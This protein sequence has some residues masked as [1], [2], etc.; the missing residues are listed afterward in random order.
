MKLR[1]TV[2][3]L[4]AVLAVV[5]TQ[6]QATAE[7]TTDAAGWRMHL[8]P[9]PKGYED[10]TGFVTGTG[11]RGTYSG[12]LLD[13][14]GSQ[15]VTWTNGKPTLRGTPSEV[16]FAAT[17][18]QSRD[19]TV[20]GTGHD[21]ETLSASPF[22]LDDTGFWGLSLPDGA[23][24]GWATAINDRGDIVGNSSGSTNEILLWSAA[25]VFAPPRVLKVDLPSATA[26]DIDDDGTILLYSE[27]GQY[28]WKDGELTR[29]KDPADHSATQA[30]AISGGRVVGVASST[31]GPGSTGFLWCGSEVST[32]QSDAPQ[33]LPDSAEATEINSSELI[34]GREHT[35]EVNGPLAVWQGLLHLGRLPVP[36]GELGSAGAVADDGTI[37]GWVSAGDPSDGGR[38]VVWVR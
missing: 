36:D 28:L 1:S 25:D 10:A 26:T 2:G 22:V 6:A 21:Y 9:L 16:E 5:A 13:D 11:G 12:Y 35:T 8:L 32:C 18:D 34:V 23:R 24:D 33:A 3:V 27:G 29:L 38:P 37:A 19:G 7:S 17:A 20:V 4:C 31:T 30:M 14:V 15:V